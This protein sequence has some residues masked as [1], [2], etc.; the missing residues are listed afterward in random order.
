MGH[1]TLAETNASLLALSGTLLGIFVNKKF[2]AIPAWFSRFSSTRHPGLVPARA[3]VAAQRHP[4]PGARDRCEKYASRPCAAISPRRSG[5]VEPIEETQAAGQA[6]MA[7]RSFS[8]VRPER[9]EAL[10]KNI[11]EASSVGDNRTFV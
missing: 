6:A 7:T 10:P 9:P 4:A 3:I 11:A 1:R 2:L 8:F 5:T